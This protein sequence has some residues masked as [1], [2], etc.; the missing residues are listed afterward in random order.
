MVFALLELKKERNQAN[1]FK[2]ILKE[3]VWHMALGLDN[4]GLST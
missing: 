3:T 4:A 1:R 2:H